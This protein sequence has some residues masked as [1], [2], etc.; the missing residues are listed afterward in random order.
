MEA[1]FAILVRPIG[2]SPN[3]KKYRTYNNNTERKSH[4]QIF[5]LQRK[6]KFLNLVGLLAALLVQLDQLL[7]TWTGLDSQVKADKKKQ[8]RIMWSFQ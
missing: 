3:K 4:T 2:F 8:I 1:I 7:L 5:F 6:T